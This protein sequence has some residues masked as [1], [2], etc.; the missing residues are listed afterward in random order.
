MVA[1]S[2]PAQTMLLNLDSC[3]DMAIRNNKELLIAK[4]KVKAAHYQHKAAITNYLPDFNATGTYQ[5]TTRSISLLSNEDKS[6]LGNLGTNVQ[7]TA[8]QTLL[9]LAAQNPA[10]ATILAPLASL[11]LATPL[12]AV[13]S[14]IVDAFDTDTRNTYAGAVIMT[15]PIF[16]GGKIHAYNKITGYAEKLAQSQESTQMQEVIMST[17]EA[18]WQVVSVAN[19]KRLAE[20]Y[21]AT[22]KKLDDDVTKMLETGVATKADELSVRVKVNEAEMA[23]TRADNGLSLSKMVLCQLCGLDINTPINLADEDLADLVLP[24]DSVTVNVDEAVNNRPEIKSLELAANIYRQKVNIVRADYLPQLALTG[25]Y[26]ITNP[27]LFN[28]FE[29]EFAG[30]WNIGVALKVHLWHWGEGIYKVKAARAE[31]NIARYTL[32]DTKEKIALQVNQCS[33]KV[34]EAARRLAMAQKDMEKADEN[35]RYAR[36]GFEEG[37]I[38]TSNVLEAQTAW[39][40][41]QSS[42]IDAQIDVKLTEISLLKA[43]GNLK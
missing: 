35:L 42:K 4:E 21:L 36:L 13:G 20:S 2:L 19:K 33:L 29:T 22:V 43:M 15:Q 24:R 9:Q 37:V 25:G 31:A 28:G 8:G 18:Y 38:P 41:A 27:S 10:L 32:N 23:V 6:M 12:N 14:K 34:N 17:D 7:T 5:H 30:M 3:R 39:L 26:L 40:Q 16:M 11:D 1:L